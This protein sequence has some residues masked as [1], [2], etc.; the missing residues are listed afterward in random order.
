MDDTDKNQ[1]KTKGSP[2]TDPGLD[3]V[4]E[5]LTVRNAIFENVV[6][7]KQAGGISKQRYLV[8]FALLL[9][10]VA[11]LTFWFHWHVQPDATA[12]L[13]VG[14][15]LTLWGVWKGIYSLLKWGSKETLEQ[16]PNRVLGSSGSTEYLVV[17]VLATGLLHFFTS[18]IHVAYWPAGENV[19]VGK[20][21][22]LYQTNGL[23]FT[24]PLTVHPAQPVAGKSFAFRARTTPL[25]VELEEPW[26]YQ[27]KE[28][29]FHPWTRIYL[30]VPHDFERKTF[31]LLRV[32][33]GA[34]LWNRLGEP[35]A[36]VETA[37]HLEI[38]YAGVTNRLTDI[39]RQTLYT[40]GTLQ[41]LEKVAAR[42]DKDRKIS[43]MGRALR[44]SG[45]AESEVQSRINVLN[46][47]PRLEPSSA[48][49]TGDAVTLIVRS[50]GQSPLLT[51]TTNITADEIQT[52][53]LQSP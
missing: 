31:R 38:V 15:G 33:P 25:R 21:Q 1:R 17:A 5:N 11:S 46:R 20:V 23:P 50:E 40:G 44:L 24:A 42:E 14:G 6:R 2:Q 39:R 37:H 22:L 3:Q 10:L 32:V 19:R 52:I 30:R 27:P 16:L 34:G 43:A 8:N 4:I 7:K 28:I 29:D 45:T 49:Q 51:I 26:G 12:S 47:I 53:P 13:F 18:S 48:F 9:G 41:D 35:G 36:S